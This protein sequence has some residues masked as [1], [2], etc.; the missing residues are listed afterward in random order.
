MAVDI[1]KGLGGARLPSLPLARLGKLNKLHKL[2]I[3]VGTL[4]ALWTGFVM[5]FYLPQNEQIGQLQAELNKAK[6]EL[7][8]L[9][10]V[11]TDL[12]NFKKEYKDMEVK[13]AAA[14]RLLPDKEEIPTLLASISQ[15]GADSGLE[16]ILFQPQPEV[17]RSFYAEIPLR[18]EVSGQFHN[19]AAFFDRVSK[20]NRIVN[21]GSVTIAPA[22]KQGEDIILTTACT[23]TTYKFIE[24]GPE[25]KKAPARKKK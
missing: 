8:R 5:W 9:R 10:R 2:L 23:A 4:G 6:V 22:R 11:E 17:P 7:D 15:L 12:R 24:S 25:G 3:V 14:L 18:V 13:F 19:V 16:F 20:L 21:V 1:K